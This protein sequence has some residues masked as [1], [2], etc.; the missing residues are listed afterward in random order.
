MERWR[1]LVAGFE[2]LAGNS[3]VEP[4]ALET[5]RGHFHELLGQVTLEPKV[6]DL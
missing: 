5:A 6:R 4:D 1:A 2:G 3:A